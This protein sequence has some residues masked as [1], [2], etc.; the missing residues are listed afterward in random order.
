MKGGT[1]CKWYLENDSLLIF[2]ALILLTLI[3][4]YDDCRDSCFCL[5][6]RLDSCCHIGRTLLRHLPPTGL[7]IFTAN[8]GLVK[9]IVGLVSLFKVEKF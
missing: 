7:L 6:I 9:S 1:S 5:C 2:H 4:F 3:L 8:N